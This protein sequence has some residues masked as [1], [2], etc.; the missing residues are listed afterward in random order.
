MPEGSIGF[1]SDHLA[2]LNATGLK[3]E[4]TFGEK[5]LNFAGPDGDGFAFVEVKDDGACPGRMAASA[6]I[7]RSA[8]STLSPC[9]CA[10][11]APRRNF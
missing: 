3:T 4:E 5:R 11:T 8:A 1:W 10:T 6:R 2:K 9:G 7:M